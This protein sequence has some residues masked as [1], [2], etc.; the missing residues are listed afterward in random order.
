MARP[1][2][3]KAR[4]APSLEALEDRRLLSLAGQPTWRGDA[5]DTWTDHTDLAP[6]VVSPLSASTDPG[7]A[8]LVRGE[9]TAQPVVLTSWLT[10]T[11][12]TWPDPTGWESSRYG[13]D[14]G[15]SSA[16]AQ[17]SWTPSDQATADLAGAGNLWTQSD[18]LI[19]A[20]AL[21]D[22]MGPQAFAAATLSTVAPTPSPLGIEEMA[23]NAATF[24]RSPLAASSPEFSNLAGPLVSSNVSPIHATLTN[25]SFH[26]VGISPGNRDLT[27]LDD[28][29]AVAPPASVD[30]S[31]IATTGGAALSGSSQ[32]SQSHG[33]AAF[34]SGYGLGSLATLPR[35]TID[36]APSKSPDDGGPIAETPTSPGGDSIAEDGEVGASDLT[37]APA[38]ESTEPLDPRLA[39]LI[40]DLIPSGR[41]TL[42]A[43]VDRF[44]DPLDALSGSMP[45][46]DTS[47]ILFASSLTVA[48]AALVLELSLRRRRGREGD[49]DLDHFPGLPGLGTGTR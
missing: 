8:M 7:R 32:A 16:A 23:A 46:W 25:P 39:D 36:P 40:L 31:S 26:E 20:S 30:E 17:T 45:G 29:S 4:I 21:T 15:L 35:P 41:P 5:A 12:S 49:E 3:R 47:I 6:A 22:A 38:S 34:G 1:K 48:G 42:D 33:S 18:Q 37:Q 14:P 27:D 11:G 13:A 43:I 44:L 9:S 10:D 24:A 28:S 2:L 19:P